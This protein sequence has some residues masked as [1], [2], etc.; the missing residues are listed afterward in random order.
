MSRYLPR[1]ERPGGGGGG[2]GG[3]QDHF[4]PKYLVGNVPA[5][6]S[7]V[8]Y[9]AGGFQYIPDT[10]NGAGIAAAV[11]AMGFGV[12]GD[13]HIRPGTYDWD[14]AGSPAAP[15]S[16]P[17]GVTIH[18][19]G[20]LT[21]LRPR[22][23]TV[24]P[25]TIFSMQPSS[26]LFDVQILCFNEE[27]ATTGPALVEVLAGLAS[28]V[29]ID[30]VDFQYVKNDNAPGSATCAIQVTTGELRI[31]Q[32]RM[33]LQNVGGVRALGSL[34]ST[35]PLGVLAREVVLRAFGSGM[36][37][38]FELR[39]ARG[40]LI[41]CEVHGALAD[42][43]VTSYAAGALQA[44]QPLAVH[45]G[46]YQAASPNPVA[47]IRSIASRELL[48]DG[49]EID[50]LNTT[51]PAIVSTAQTGRIVACDVGGT[52]DTSGGTRHVIT[53][54]VF[55]GLRASNLHAVTDEVAHNIFTQ[56]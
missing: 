48:L 39:N 42:H 35:T 5:G 46:Y 8:P 17:S 41:N 10:G 50:L 49:V 36:Q 1:I 44:G 33:F 56:E 19:A 54:N 38:G 7:A 3:G 23:T 24:G 45:G 16:V 9:S 40:T 47:I 32:C 28:P 4:A 31:R 51:E 34:V 29:I 22:R 13:V 6:D 11:A 52:V 30:N 53:S 26:R 12:A 18:G 14:V 20:N 15:I 25:A 27:A 2:G 55:R 37:E 21:Q 43:A